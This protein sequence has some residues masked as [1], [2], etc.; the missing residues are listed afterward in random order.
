MLHPSFDAYFFL[1]EPLLLELDLLEPLLLFDPELFDPPDLDAA[2]AMLRT[3]LQQRATT[4]EAR[5]LFRLG[6]SR[7]FVPL[8]FSANK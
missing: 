2:L 7:S 5:H 8:L 6:E 1:L 3:P 4:A